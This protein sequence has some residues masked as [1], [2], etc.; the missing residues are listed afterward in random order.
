MAATSSQRDLACGV[1]LP[2][3]VV[4]H[5]RGELPAHCGRPPRSWLRLTLPANAAAAL[6]LAVLHED[7]GA[8]RT[9][10]HQ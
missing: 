9:P 8:P 2:A 4:V 7:A 5:T 1:G 10:R 3:P 6:G